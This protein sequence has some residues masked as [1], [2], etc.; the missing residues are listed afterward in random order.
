MLALLLCSENWSNFPFRSDDALPGS[1]LVWSRNLYA[2]HL[3][4]LPLPDGVVLMDRSLRSSGSLFGKRPGESEP[5][6]CEKVGV[7]ETNSILDFSAVGSV[8]CRGG[9]ATVFD[10]SLRTREI[11]KQLVM[12][13]PHSL[14]CTVPLGSAEILADVASFRSECD[15][16]TVGKSR[17][18]RTHGAPRRSIYVCKYKDLVRPAAVLCTSSATR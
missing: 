15:R 13:P 3:T 6:P 4:A 7:F 8:V 11:T 14:R 2:D 12:G 1:W 5:E 16:I 17:F 18:Y 9:C 10:P